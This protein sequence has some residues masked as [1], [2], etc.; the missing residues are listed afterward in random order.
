[1]KKSILVVDDD[2]SILSIFEFILNKKQYNCITTEIKDEALKIINTQKI[3]M[4]FIDA[5]LKKDSGIKLFNE[6]KKTKQYLP[7]VLMTG[8]KTKALVSEMYE[9]GADLAVYKPFDVEEVI[10]LINETLMKKT[11]KST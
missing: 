8:H 10:R 1:M 11:I 7:I 2:K 4:M 9:A 3:D 5:R 6:I